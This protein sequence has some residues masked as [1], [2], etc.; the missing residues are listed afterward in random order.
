[1]FLRYT[2]LGVGH[3]IALRRFTKDC[4]H[5]DSAPLAEEAMDVEEVGSNDDC[6]DEHDDEHDDERLEA[7]LSK[8][9]EELVEDE[10][11]IEG[12]ESEEGEED[13]I[14]DLRLSF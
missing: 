12:E 11:E 4:F 5:F 8:D 1:M 9:S 10:C 3:P 14:D 7:Y 6:H 13:R 2:H